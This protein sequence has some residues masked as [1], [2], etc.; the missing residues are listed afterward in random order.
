M[1]SCPFYGASL[2]FLSAV[3]E[4]HVRDMEPSPH[5]ITQRGNRC[6]LITSAHSPCAREMCGS[7]PE[8]A[9]CRRN[10]EVNGTS[11]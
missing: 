6:A 8:W 10:P 11:R 3:G 2:V 5:L 4:I 9:V 1:N 7:A